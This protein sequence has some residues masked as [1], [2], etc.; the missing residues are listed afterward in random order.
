MRIPLA[1]RQAYEI[2]ERSGGRSPR[3]RATRKRGEPFRLAVP[4]IV[5]LDEPAADLAERGALGWS[6]LEKVA[7]ALADGIDSRR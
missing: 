3:L 1:R 4:G 2:N 5:L 7:Q 6:S